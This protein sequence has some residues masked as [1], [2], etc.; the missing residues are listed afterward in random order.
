MK[1]NCRVATSTKRTKHTQ[2]SII[3]DS[4]ICHKLLLYTFEFWKYTVI[5]HPATIGWNDYDFLYFVLLHIR[6]FCD[7]VYL[8][9][10]PPSWQRKHP[11]FSTNSILLIL[12]STFRISL[13]T[14]SY[15]FWMRTLDSR[16]PIWLNRMSSSL[17]SVLINCSR[18]IWAHSNSWWRLQLTAWHGIFVL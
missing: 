5:L 10:I 4:F 2:D 12:R 17:S 9:T 11:S 13:L 16:S 1:Q 14:S 8:K 7:L 6:G 18:L 15:L 3:I